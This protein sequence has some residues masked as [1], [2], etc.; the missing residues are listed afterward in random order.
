MIKTVGD[1]LRE[2]RTKKGLAL[3]TIAKETGIS[4]HHL[5]AIELDQF[6]LV[7]E[8]KLDA[9]LAAYAGLVDLDLADLKSSKVIQ[10]SE[11]RPET[12][13]DELIVKTER[14]DSLDSR[15][16]RR[17]SRGHEEKKKA[18][19]LP[20]FI[21]SLVA[22]GILGF[23]GW[24][25]VKNSNVDFSL[26]NLT[27]KSSSSAATE[28]K[29]EVVEESF[30]SESSS[31]SEI[32]ESSTEPS[33]TTPSSSEEPKVELTTEGEG[34]SMEVTIKGATTPIEFAITF[35]GEASGMEQSWVGL[36]NVES[37]IGGVLL[38]SGETHE[39]K[40]AADAKE[41]ELSFG[42]TEGISIK[43]A[44]EDLDMSPITSRSNSTITL[45]VE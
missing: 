37:N 26:P 3:Q 17:H 10:E 13:Y 19:L 23:V 33:E 38:D 11:I 40:F 21:L 22:L 36:T 31:S 9:Y 44:G 30:S 18:S 27:R 15:S 16:S 4:D 2:A 14:P 5:L 1:L 7:P 6:S 39:D 20:L 43:I 42:I 34:D 12:S 28:D 35:D 29:E 41:V 32:D 45:I 24:T 25:F 8:D